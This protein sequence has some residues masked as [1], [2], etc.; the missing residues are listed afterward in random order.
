MARITVIG[1]TGYAGSAVVTEAAARGWDVTSYSRT[2]PGDD[3]RVAGV[4]YVTGSLTD[5]EVRQR[6]VADTDVVL[7][8]LSPRG[9]LDGRLGEVDRSLADLAGAAGVRIGVV[10][11]FSSLR[12]EEGGQRM[13][14]GDHLPPQF[15]SEARQMNAILTDLL[16]TPESVD[17]IF[18]SPAA[19]FGAYAPGEKRG[20]YRV[21]GEVALHDADGVSAISGPDFA[22][23]ILDEFEKPR[24]RRQQVGFAY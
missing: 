24:H 12:L 23:A 16:A 11:G 19:E 18:F 1:G 3:M 8:A 7:S 5:P 20:E 13:A 17:W 6:A 10:G 4:T 15:A 2:L 9:E 22:S 14:E 21:G